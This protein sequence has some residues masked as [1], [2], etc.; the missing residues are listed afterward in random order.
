M[1]RIVLGL[2]IIAAL[3][4]IG[5]A[6]PA[7]ASHPKVTIA[8]GGFYFCDPEF[9]LGLCETD[10]AAGTTVTWEFTGAHT[11]TECGDP[12]GPTTPPNPLWD[13]GHLTTGDTFSYTFNTPGVYNY[14]CRIHP[15]FM[16]G[17]INVGPAG[18]S[19][20][21]VA[22]IDAAA[23]AG[24][25]ASGPYTGTSSFA[26]A[27]AIATAVALVA[28]LIGAAWFARRRHLLRAG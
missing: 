28:G 6:Q 11:T 24:L 5:S 10:I 2:A 18:P 23:G 1:R 13:S 26:T 21:G 8:V 4:L 20:G 14:F 19:V 3:A 22:E 9:H 15:L 7:S 16:F 12:C 27:I 17:Q 25:D